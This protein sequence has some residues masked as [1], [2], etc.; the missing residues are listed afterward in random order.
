MSMICRTIFL[1]SLNAIDDKAHDEGTPSSEVGLG[2]T[3]KNRFLVDGASDDLVLMY[4][5][6]PSA[7]DVVRNLRGDIVF[8]HQKAVVCLYEKGSSSVLRDR[9][10]NALRKYE[11]ASLLID[12][13]PCSPDTILTND[14]I[15]VERGDFL[16][17]E[18]AYASALIRE[19]ET[20]HLKPLLSVSGDQ[21]ATA[22]QSTEAKRKR[23][24][25]DIEHNALEGFGL[26]ILPAYSSEKVCGAIKDAP[27]VHKAIIDRFA[28]PVVGRLRQHLDLESASFEDVFKDVQRSRLQRRL[29]VRCRSK[30]ASRSPTPRSDHLPGV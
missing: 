26:V 30:T 6:A 25:A 4:V 14:V 1:L 2:R 3:A 20:D 5:S 8:D 16:K 12:A 17:Q 23:I 27:D 10:T 29:R 7:P 15:A 19:I 22:L 9:V 24:E 28:D 18:I 11:I 21:I 13:K